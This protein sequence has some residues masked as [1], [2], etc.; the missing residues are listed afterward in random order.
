VARC[1]SLPQLANASAQASWV[2]GNKNREYRCHQLGQIA[3]LGLSY[4]FGGKRKAKDVE[5]NYD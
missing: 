3:Y 1:R 4:N 2:P 5:F